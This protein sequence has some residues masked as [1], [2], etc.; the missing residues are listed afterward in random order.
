MIGQRTTLVITHRLVGLEAVDEILVLEE[1]RIV[2]RGDHAAL[3]RRGGL[4]YSMWEVQNQILV[5]ALP[6]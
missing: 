5:E 3:L 6:T 4:Y 2:E 1:G